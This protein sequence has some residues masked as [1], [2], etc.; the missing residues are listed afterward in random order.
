MTDSSRQLAFLTLRAIHQGAFADVALD[1]TLYRDALSNADR[2]LLTEL[3]YGCVRR[4]R[5]LD[6]LI[7]QLARKP[8][9][10]QPPNV[11]S[12]LHLGLYQLRYLSQIPPSAAVNTTV[13]LAK[14]N[15]LTGL[16]GLINGILRQYLRRSAEGD[17]LT[18]PT[19]PVAR[20]G[21]QHSF[22]D[23]MVQVWLQQFDQEQTE[24]LCQWLNHPPHI[25]LRVNLLRATPE[26]VAAALH[27]VGVETQPIPHLPQ[28]LRL[29][30]PPGA[31]AQLPGFQEGW[32]MVQ[33]ASAQLVTHLLDPQP[34]DHIVDACAAPGGKTAHMA[35]CMGDRGIIWACDRTASR[36]KKIHANAERLGLTCIQVCEADSRQT[37]R[38]TAQ[39]DRVLVDAPC[40][41]LGTLNRHADARWRQTPE[42]VAELAQL[43]AALLHHAA[44]W[45]K[46]GGILVYSTCTLHPDENEAIA[47]SF[48]THHPHWQID[49]LP[50][51][52][53]ATPFLTA[54]GWIRVLPPEHNM[55]GFFMVRWR[56][57]G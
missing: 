39:A 11:R 57:T 52:H 16:S 14:A 4:A 34:G 42:T 23:W 20:L 49:P 40:S 27:Q 47:Q 5:T 36:L 29:Q 28:G 6:V 48:L 21:V 24:A 41:G 56:H 55:D 13:E 7:D 8:A 1:R 44:T 30:T 37:T 26:Q 17:P 2:R 43:Q 10:H 3:V 25:D 35:E 50:T 18:L 53:P 32:W 51:H 22:P 15:G 31:I 9:Q 12:L 54:A 46:P 19:D 33:D 45:V 38:F